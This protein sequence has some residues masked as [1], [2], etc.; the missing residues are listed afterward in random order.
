M[1]RILRFPPCPPN[2]RIMIQITRLKLFRGKN[3]VDFFSFIEGYSPLLKKRE[4]VLFMRLFSQAKINVL[5]KNEECDYS[6]F[7]A[8][9]K[10]DYQEVEKDII[11]LSKLNLITV[12]DE[13]D[14]RNIKIEKVRNISD[15]MK[16]ANFNLNLKNVLT[17]DK[18]SEL[19]YITGE[20]M[21]TIENK[22]E[23]NPQ[24]YTSFYS[25]V[26]SLLGSEFTLSSDAI[27]IIK[28]HEENIEMETLHQCAYLSAIK[29]NGKYYIS[30]SHLEF[31]LKQK[32]FE[33]PNKF[34][35]DDH[36][37]F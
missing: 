6:K 2:T 8:N 30:P 28:Q 1:R 4:I 3:S 23:L 29:T 33:D 37:D 36:Q 35:A 26:L 5:T 7:L 18:Y 32:L 27:K 19:V 9:Y 31:L 21:E 25:G 15:L 20:E 11:K 10:L 16:D 14:C 12:K 22:H 13:G 17:E 34:N 24:I